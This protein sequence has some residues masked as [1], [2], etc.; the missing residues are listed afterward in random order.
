MAT[1]APKHGMALTIG[2][3]LVDLFIGAMP[4]SLN[5]LCAA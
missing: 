2:Y 4:F 3:M 1:V 5:E